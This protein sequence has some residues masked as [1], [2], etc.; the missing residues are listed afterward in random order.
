MSGEYFLTKD[1][2]EKKKKDEVLAKRE[3]KRAEKINAKNQVFD[4]PEEDLPQI[5]DKKRDKKAEEKES[6]SKSKPDINDLKNKF[7]KKK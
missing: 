7:L 3:H 5:K 1:E 6:K 2:K 4:A